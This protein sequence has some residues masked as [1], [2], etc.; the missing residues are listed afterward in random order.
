MDPILSFS[1]QREAH[2]REP[3]RKRNAAGPWHRR[4]GW[5]RIPRDA[6]EIRSAV[7]ARRAGPAV[8]GAI[9]VIANLPAAGVARGTRRRR[10]ALVRLFVADAG[11]VA[12]AA[13]DLSP[14]P[15]VE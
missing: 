7:R 9:A 6:R 3:G 2:K 14:A 8:Q 11:A 1:C 5:R 15:G 13:A 12:G 4:S 10:A